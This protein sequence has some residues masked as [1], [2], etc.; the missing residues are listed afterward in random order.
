METE[1]FHNWLQ[2]HM[3]SRDSLIKQMGEDENKKGKKET[4]RF[5]IMCTFA[6]QHSLFLCT[7]PPFLTI[8]K[9]A[10]FVC[11]ILDRFSYLKSSLSLIHI[12]THTRNLQSTDS[13]PTV[14]M[15]GV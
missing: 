13:L 2:T 15:A 4:G 11:D 1:S 5:E 3:F 14:A 6:N 7:T 8:T 9:S 10:V 12:N